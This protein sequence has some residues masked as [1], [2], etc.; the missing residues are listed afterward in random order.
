MITSRVLLPQRPILPLQFFQ[1]LLGSLGSLVIIGHSALEI[2]A[3]VGVGLQGTRVGLVG[4]A[5]VHP[6][7]EEELVLEVNLFAPTTA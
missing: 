2:L 7:I 3:E 1:H 5:E 6:R 4:V